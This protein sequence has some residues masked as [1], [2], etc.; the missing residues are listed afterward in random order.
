VSKLG[1][2]IQERFKDTCLNRFCNKKAS[3]VV[4]LF[5]FF[6]IVICLIL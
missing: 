6:A 3:L 2:F 4:D 5:S 1:K